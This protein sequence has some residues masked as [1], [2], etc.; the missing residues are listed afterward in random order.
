MTDPQEK[1]FPYE[2]PEDVYSNEFVITNGLSVQGNQGGLFYVNPKKSYGCVLIYC[3][4]NMPW[5][6][7]ESWFRPN[8]NSRNLEIDP[9]KTINA[10]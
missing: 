1:E 9:S 7:S 4:P 3:F 5:I 10:Q 8:P 2:A 6:Y